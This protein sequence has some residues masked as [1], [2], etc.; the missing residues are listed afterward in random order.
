MIKTNKEKIERSSKGKIKN[1][2]GKAWKQYKKV[3]WIVKCN[4]LKWRNKR[5]KKRT[6][7]KWKEE[8]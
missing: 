3:V 5:L 7:R 6:K 8:K 1:K 2:E 4:I